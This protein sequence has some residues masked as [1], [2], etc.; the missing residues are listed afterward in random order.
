VLLVDEAWQMAWCDL[1]P[2]GAVA[3]EFVLIG[4][5]GQIPPVVTVETGRFET[6]ARPPHFPAPEVILGDTE[7]RA[8]A[9]VLELPATR[10]LP[11]ESLGYVQD[12]Y[13]FQFDAW[14]S[15][16]ERG[17]EINARADT[18]V[19]RALR[20]LSGATVAA[21]TIPTD[22]AGPPLE[23]DDAL[24]T[25]VASAVSQALD[26]G[27]QVRKDGA[28]HPL[29]PEDIGITA[30]HRVMNTALHLALPAGLRG[31]V[32]VDT[33]ERWQGLERDLMIAVHPLSG[34]VKPSEFDL[35]TGR[36]CVMISR[37]RAGL[38]LVTRDHIGET[39]ARNV[40]SASQP[41]GRPDV[42]GR[43]HHIHLGLWRRLADAN[44]VVAEH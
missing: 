5:P 31:R 24:A 7:L 4:D 14:S 10:R 23:R 3:A 11:N 22:N 44:L 42:A 9:Q 6:S 27:A 30:T 39:L 17:I 15:P 34:T 29:R 26:G 21:I 25:L 36:L 8:R 1:M 38:L 18:A 13:D 37:H 41:V 16:G 2:L 32:V 12:F 33:P 43:G 40:P 35:E 19:A 20:G 28:V